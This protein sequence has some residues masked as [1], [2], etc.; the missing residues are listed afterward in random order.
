M[1]TVL[2]LICM[3]FSLAAAAVQPQE[4]LADP[5]LEQR[6]R[7]ISREL[8]CPVCQGEDIDESNAP[9]ASDLR[10]IVRQRLVAG[11][12]DAEVLDFLKRR[13]GDFIL[14]NPPL[15]ENTLVLWLLPLGVLAAGIGAV[16][17]FLRRARN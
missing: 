12:S 5:V 4:M 3:F 10:R 14:M 9:L 8:R 11:D 16:F 17:V 1:K 15:Q 13:Y 2:F 6:A 7:S